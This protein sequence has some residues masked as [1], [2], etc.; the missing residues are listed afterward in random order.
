MHRYR[1]RRKLQRRRRATV[2]AVFSAALAL[3]VGIPTLAAADPVNDALNGLGLGSGSGDYGGGG[4][5]SPQQTEPTYTP[6]LHGTNPHG[7][8]AGAVID[9][10]PSSSPPY[11]GD[12]SSDEPPNGEEIILGH[13]R[14]DQNE[15]G[16]Y[17]GQVTLLWLFGNPIVQVTSK[18]GEDN[19]GPLQPLQEQLLD[20]VCDGSDGQLCLTILKMDSSSTSTSSTNQFQLAGA[21]VGGEEGIN[22]NMLS[23][24]GNISE[25]NGCQTA[26]GDSNVASVSAGGNPVVDA[27]Q[28]ESTSDCNGNVTQNSTTLKLGGEDVPIPDAGC[29]A[30]SETPFT[31]LSPLL[32]AFCN[33]DDANGSQTGPFYGVREGLTAFALITDEESPESLA[34]VTTAA[35]ES[36]AV[37]PAEA[38][39]PTAPTPPA[40]GV[41][42][43]AGGKK[44]AGAEGGPGEGA[45]ADAGGAGAD[46]GGTGAAAAGA[47]PG[48][49]ELAF[50]GA[51]LLA[52][53]MVGGALILG[54]LAMTKTAG[55]PHRRTV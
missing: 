23:S 48:A 12:P 3:V 38:V 31:P 29:P 49:G 9:I 2:V 11:S 47:G 16:S 35:S 44:G 15:D 55:R 26:H 25:S 43:G 52:L 7:Q 20:Q 50:T 45:G 4:T 34:K 6:P 46:A 37:A 22:A 39:T 40:A 13:S 27:L 10:Q 14:G 18:P 17:S 28:S 1:R 24:N 33:A 36:Q 54:G 42:P 8:G 19:H 32:A 30:G 51:D 21:S 53:G 5:V 41:A